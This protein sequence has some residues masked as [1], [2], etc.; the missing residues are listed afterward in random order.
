MLEK[1][2]NVFLL[3]I[4][5]FG[6]T[7]FHSPIFLFGPFN[8][9]SIQTDHKPVVIEQLHPTSDQ[10]CLVSLPCPHHRNKKIKA[11]YLNLITW[12]KAL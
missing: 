7:S 12:V 1:L 5:N 9:D 2:I 11:K 3:L 6:P 4:Y 10:M 8:L